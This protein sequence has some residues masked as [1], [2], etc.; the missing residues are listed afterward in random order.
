MLPQRV[1]VS[2]DAQ[3]V[4]FIVQ[5]VV[6]VFSMTLNCIALI[7]LFKQTPPH[8]SM[9]RNYLILT[10]IWMIIADVV[11]DISLDGVPLFLI[12]GGYCCGW[13][14]T[15]GIPIPYIVVFKCILLSNIGV[16]ILIYVIYR[17]QA[18]LFDSRPFKMNIVTDNKH[19]NSH[20]TYIYVLLSLLFICSKTNRLRV[21]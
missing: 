4:I 10:Q 20:C 14:C 16:S 7:C 11:Y 12:V 17:Q 13:L 6:F 9:L 8:Q 19:D 15:T 3:S 5:K 1:F 18:I 21:Q 2:L